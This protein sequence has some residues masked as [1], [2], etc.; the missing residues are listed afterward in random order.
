MNSSEQLIARMLA[1]AP[2]NDADRTITSAFLDGNTT[3]IAFHSKEC[4][5]DEDR[6]PFS[7]GSAIEAGSVPSCDEEDGEGTGHRC[8]SR[9]E[10]RH[11]V[12]E[13]LE[14]KD[15]ES[16]ADD[17]TDPTSGLP[18]IGCR[19]YYEHRETRDLAGR[20]AGTEETDSD[21]DGNRLSGQSQEESLSCFFGKRRRKRHDVLCVSV[22]CGLLWVIVIGVLVAV[23]RGSG[24]T[25]VQPAPQNGGGGDGG[26]GV[27]KPNKDKPPKGPKLDYLRRK[28]R[29]AR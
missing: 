14:I 12:V 27:D 22:C 28:L 23:L 26:P 19:R 6:H 3:T 5:A 11:P 29:P 10:S 8:T 4:D 20:K 18:A 25:A 13:E 15:V 9:D 21:D 7:T 16:I 24:A 1:E 2:G 17:L